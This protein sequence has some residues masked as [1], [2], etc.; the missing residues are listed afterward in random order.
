[1]KALTLMT[2]LVV[3]SSLTN[4]LL[5]QP[6]YILSD[7]AGKTI[8]VKDGIKGMAVS[9]LKVSAGE[10]YRVR[11]VEVILS[12]GTSR[13]ATMNLTSEIMDLRNWTGQ[14]HAGDRI[15]IDIKSVTRKTPSGS[16]ENVGVV[17]GVMHL[18]II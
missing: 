1:M 8:D 11:N 3:S 18:M 15:T 13:I 7:Q 2:L 6:V 10:G 14:Y 12:R 9:I 16:E 17:G 4:M 5:A